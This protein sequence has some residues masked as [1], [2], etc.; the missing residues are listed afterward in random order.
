MMNKVVYKKTWLFTSWITLYVALYKSM[1]RVNQGRWLNYHCSKPVKTRKPSWR[2]GYAR[3]RRHS[4]MAV[5]HH[6]G[7][8]RTGNSAIRSADPENP[9][10]EPNMEWIGFTFFEIFTFKLYCD[11]ETG[12][13][14]TQGHR[15]RHHQIGWPRKPDPR[16]KHHVDRQNCCEVVAIFVYPRWPSAA[17]LDFIEPHIAPFDPPTPKTPEGLEPNMEWIG[18]TV[19]RYSHLNY[20]VTLKLG[21]GVT[22]SHRKWHYS[23][24]HMT[25]YSSS[26]VTMPLSITVFEI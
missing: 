11:L 6:L 10:I 20:T 7:Y 17:I 8:Y 14:V 3:Q 4:K 1:S 21:F 19:P 13:R 26:I 2:K 9:R 25:L 18:C 16:S 12:V 22:Q 5:S 24:A 23:I 15:K